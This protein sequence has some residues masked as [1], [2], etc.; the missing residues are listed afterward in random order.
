MHKNLYLLAAL[1]V[2]GLLTGA[3]CGTLTGPSETGQAGGGSGGGTASAGN[4]DQCVQVTSFTRGQNCGSSTSASMTL[5][6]NCNVSIDAEFCLERT[7]G[8]LECGRYTDMRPGQ[9][10]SYFTCNGTG[11]YSVSA[12]VH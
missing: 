5:R 7:N 4:A 2:A 6:N 3:G 12:T 10:T 1:L 8:T 11:R 9:T